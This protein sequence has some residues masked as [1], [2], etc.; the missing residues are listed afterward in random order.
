MDQG[1]WR[2][3]RRQIETLRVV[4][5]LPSIKP[6]RV[7]GSWE[8]RLTVLL[9]LSV[10]V[11]FLLTER[12]RQLTRTIVIMKEESRLKVGETI[13]SLEGRALDGKPAL[14]SFRK[15]TVIYILSPDCAWCHRNVAN[16]NALKDA[17]SGKYDVVGVSLSP[18]ALREHTESARYTFPILASASQNTLIALKVAGTP[19]TVVVSTDGKVVRAWS[20][21]F[22][23][24]NASEIEEFFSIRLPGLTD[25]TKLPSISGG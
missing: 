4:V 13:P 8:G 6:L 23:G 12:I 9:M 19:T 22:V 11:N 18:I 16:I 24:T 5:K 10:A 17:V 3:H 2:S 7:P 20:G 15:P 25:A 21:V 14:V 1:V